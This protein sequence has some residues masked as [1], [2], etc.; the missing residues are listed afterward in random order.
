MRHTLTEE[1]IISWPGC[2]RL[3]TTSP[4]HTPTR[5]TFQVP[6]LS[7]HQ[8]LML[9]CQSTWGSSPRSRSD[10]FVNVVGT[11]LTHKLTQEICVL[12]LKVRWIR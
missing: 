11:T 1:M 2:D 8:G 4:H 7:L 9:G 3:E 6:R 5:L 10:D 12:V